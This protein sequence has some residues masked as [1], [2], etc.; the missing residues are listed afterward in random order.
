MVAGTPRVRS[1]HPRVSKQVWFDA[2]SE[3]SNWG[4]VYGAYGDQPLFFTHSS[5]EVDHGRD[6]VVLDIGV[7]FLAYGAGDLQEDRVD[8]ELVGLSNQHVH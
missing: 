1:V 7:G 8:R 4:V 6:V 5:G 3:N 2:G